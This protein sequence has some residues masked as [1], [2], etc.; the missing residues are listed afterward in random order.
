MG[1]HSG[2]FVTLGYMKNTNPIITCSWLLASCLL[3]GC[4]Q[5]P[6]D[7]PLGKVKLNSNKRIEVNYEP[8]VTLTI[9]TNTSLDGVS[10]YFYDTNSD[11]LVVKNGHTLRTFIFALP[12]KSNPTTKGK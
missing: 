8:G 7:H 10:N 9:N 4:N 2:K 6:A 11:Q 1:G 5:E 12:V 3:P